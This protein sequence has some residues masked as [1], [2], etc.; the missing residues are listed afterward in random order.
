MYLSYYGLTEEPFRLTPDPRFLH[1]AEPH[2][3]ALLRILES[4]AF[5]KGIVLAMGPIGTGKTTL[6]HAAQHILDQKLGGQSRLATAFVVN[7]TLTRDEFLETVLDEF[8]IT[9]ESSSKPRRLQALHEFLLANY[10]R[11]GIAVLILD[12][13]HLLSP[14]LL[15]EIR[16]LTNIDSYR[17]N[18]LQVVLCGQPELAAVLAKPEMKAM[19]Q[20]IAV[21]A[22][23]RA[24]TLSETRAYVAGRLHKAGLRGASPFS[25][26]FIA[27]L[28]TA[29][30]GVPRLINLI[31]DNALVIG[32]KSH[33]VCLGD[34]VVQEAA[35][36]CRLDIGDDRVP[37][38]HMS[39]GPSALQ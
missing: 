35:G 14:E 32:F 1:L 31:C 5:R 11:G 8:G 24:L 10:N 17:S 9:C 28:F 20:R 27:G 15:G 22:Q 37:A 12:E 30:S 34:D 26:Q 39:T 7:P 4:L 23:L 3:K 18:L 36:G 16:L 6:L 25:E 2:R 21:V 33:T 13:A 19:Q 38:V 29:T